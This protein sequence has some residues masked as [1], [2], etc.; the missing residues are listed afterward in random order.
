M[1]VTLP[2]EGGGMMDANAK[3]STQEYPP[4]IAIEDAFRALT[5]T[6]AE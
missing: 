6:D 2:R 5:P 1:S 3:K 4:K